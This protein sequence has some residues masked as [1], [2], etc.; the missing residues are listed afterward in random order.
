[1]AKDAFFCIFF[2]E[3]DVGFRSKIGLKTAQSRAF[4]LSQIFIFSHLYALPVRF[5]T[6]I[7]LS[8]GNI[9]QKSPQKIVQFII[10]Y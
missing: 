4:S 6:I 5:Y 3:K 7:A 10:I 8:K 9:P 1:M 2:Y